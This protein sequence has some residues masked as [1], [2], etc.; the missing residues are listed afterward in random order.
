[1]EHAYHGETP[2]YKILFNEETAAKVRP[3]LLTDSGCII[4]MLLL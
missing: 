4:I 2:N 1:M 3:A